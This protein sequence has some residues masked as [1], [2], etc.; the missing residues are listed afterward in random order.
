MNLILNR[1]SDEQPD[2]VFWMRGMSTLIPCP[3]HIQQCCSPSLALVGPQDGAGFTVKQTE[4][5]CSSPHPCPQRRQACAGVAVPSDQGMAM[6][7]HLRED[8][9]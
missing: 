6:R 5:S 3:V 8:H 2:N 4:M 1:N 7:C 9:C